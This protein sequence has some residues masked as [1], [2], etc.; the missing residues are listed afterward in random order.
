MTTHAEEPLRIELEQALGRPITG[1]KRLSGGDINDAFAVACEDGA[2]LFAKTLSAAPATM[3]AVEARG[4]EWLRGGHGLRIPQVH[5][6]RDGG[7]GRRCWLVLEW[8]ES[9]PPSAD[10]DA[11]LGRGLASLHRMGAASYGLDF[12]NY[13]G[14]LPQV[15][16]P[17][18]DWPAFY[19][20][21]R[22]WPQV[23]RAIH[24]GIA[25]PDMRS[26]VERLR[27]RLDDLLGSP[28]EGPSRLHG[29]LWSGNVMCDARGVP[30]L[31][32]P[33]PYGGDRE[34]DLAMMAL[35]GGFSDRALAA[36]EEAYP[37]RPGAAE[38][39]PLYQL[40]PL[41]V[42]ANLFGGPY[43]ARVEALV[44]RY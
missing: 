26:G 41:L 24:A 32:D 15:N 43:I 22:L 5:M 7:A 13:V 18:D 38:R 33:A 4:L 28:S 27:A 40:Y 21:A 31:I 36:Y 16:T 1:L 42:H 30:A 3:A 10:F 9:G 35:F 20:A 37:L 6:A 11:Q 12:D 44:A 25:T 39:R 8:I 23:E 14:S 2:Q 34:V 17:I 19:G 29:D